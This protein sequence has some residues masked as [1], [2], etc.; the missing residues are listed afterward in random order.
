M[1]NLV[2]TSRVAIA[3]REFEV[4]VFQRT[5]GGFLAKTYFSPVD[6][7]IHDGPSVDE[8]LTRHRQVLPLAVNSRELLS[9]RH[10]C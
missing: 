3:E 2:H 10:S 5:G 6:V 8:V 9:A 7:I 4:L 1:E